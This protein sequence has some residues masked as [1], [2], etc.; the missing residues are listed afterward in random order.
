M[1]EWATNWVCKALGEA[2]DARN[3]GARDV[4][5]SPM[6]EDKNAKGAHP[7]TMKMRWLVPLGIIVLD[8]RI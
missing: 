4:V 6:K 1:V 3:K 5:G 7:K 8:T 2:S